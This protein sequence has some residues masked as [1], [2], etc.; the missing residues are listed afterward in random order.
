MRT[1][2]GLSRPLEIRPTQCATV[3]QPKTKHRTTSASQGVLIQAARSL[4]ATPVVKGC[5]RR[6]LLVRQICTTHFKA[7]RRIVRFCDVR[8]FMCRV[9][10]RSYI[11][12]AKVTPPEI[13]QVTTVLRRRL[14]AALCVQPHA[15]SPHEPAEAPF[16]ARRASRW[17]ML[18]AGCFAA[19]VSA[20]VYLFVLGQ[21]AVDR[22]HALQQQLAA[23]QERLAALHSSVLT[24]PGPAAI[25]AL[26]RCALSVVVAIPCNTEQI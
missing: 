1:H 20:I 21:S 3:T 9:L 11:A 19:L 16:C 5:E 15:A 17:I 6:M 22:S 14:S 26:Q 4:T 7:P 25:A 10:L 13:V 24:L 8:K 23:Q 18:S 2:E 12:G